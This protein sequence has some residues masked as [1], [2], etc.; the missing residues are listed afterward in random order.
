MIFHRARGLESSK[1]DYYVQRRQTMNAVNVK[2]S[3]CLMI[4]TNHRCLAHKAA[5][6]IILL[7][8]QNSSGYIF[9]TYLNRKHR[10]Y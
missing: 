4:V 2:A 8:V 5:K 10:E 6:K 9:T 7:E 3:A 1:D